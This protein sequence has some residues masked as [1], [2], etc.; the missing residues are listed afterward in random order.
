MSRRHETENLLDGK[1]K[2]G[3]TINVDDRQT[4]LT[5]IVL[6]FH[7]H[8]RKLDILNHDLCRLFGQHA[9]GANG[10]KIGYH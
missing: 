5:G 6:N 8:L 9:P 10:S 3:I 4:D 1:N 2:K 7:C